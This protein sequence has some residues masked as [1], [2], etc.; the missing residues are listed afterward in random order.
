VVSTTAKWTA[1]QQQHTQLTAELYSTESSLKEAEEEVREL[2]K[3]VSVLLPTLSNEYSRFND[4]T[5]STL[6]S[7]EG[8][9]EPAEEEAGF[10]GGM[11]GGGS[12]K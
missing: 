11:F 10:F 9:P 2:T 8:S 1:L 3:K 6:A 7:P 5:I 4:A 12:K